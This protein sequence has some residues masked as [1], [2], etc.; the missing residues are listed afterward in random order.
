[1]A[2]T[3]PGRPDLHCAMAISNVDQPTINQRAP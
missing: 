3:H 1:M 2:I